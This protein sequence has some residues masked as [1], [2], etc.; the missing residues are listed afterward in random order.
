MPKPL[1]IE[2]LHQRKQLPATQKSFGKF[3]AKTGGEV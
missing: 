1:E 3:V 2:T